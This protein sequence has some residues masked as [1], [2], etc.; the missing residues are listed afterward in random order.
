[1]KITGAKLLTGGPGKNYVTLKILH[2]VHHRFVPREAAEFDEREA[3]RYEYNPGSHPVVRL[4]D[5][6]MWNY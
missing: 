1:M 5:G 4:E 6:T 3:A 2:D